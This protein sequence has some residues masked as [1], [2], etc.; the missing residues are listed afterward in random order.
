MQLDPVLAALL[1]GLPPEQAEGID[2]QR[3]REEATA[4]A[5][6]GR[7]T[8]PIPEDLGLEWLE[9]PGR[10]GHRIRVLL[11]VPAGLYRQ[12]RRPVIIWSHGGAFTHGSPMSVL[13]RTATLAQRVPCVVLGVDYRLLPEHRFPSALNDVVDVLAWCREHADEL[14]IDADRIVVAGDS[15][16]GNISAATAIV[17]RD[18]GWQLCGQLLEV[19]LLDLTETSGSTHLA[20]TAAPELARG[21]RSS[22]LRYLAN[23]AA[24]DNPLSSPLCLTD[25]KGLAPAFMLNVE[26]D[27]LRDD[28]TN[29]ARLLQSAGVE[30]RT[31]LV[32]G[33]AHGT[34]G[35]TVAFRQCRDAEDAVVRWLQERLASMH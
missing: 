3:E 7:L 35:F 20:A 21:L 14:G 16:G 25:A 17:A 18:R 24:V 15:A 5:I 12:P 26:V 8:P 10:E 33:M 13:S 23:G 31:H 1:A 32:P 19:P 9:V 27:P 28:V 22:H 4:E 2:A 34:Q 30:V 6:R 29:Y 11:Q